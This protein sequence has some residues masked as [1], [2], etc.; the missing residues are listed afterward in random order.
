LTTYDFAIYRG[1]TFNGA[2]F[3]VSVNASPPD[4]T[5]ASI[6]MA[7]RS[8]INF[9]VASTLSTGAGL[10]ITDAAQGKFRIDPQ[11][12]NMAPGAYSYDIQLTVGGVVKTYVRG[13]VTVTGDQ[14]YA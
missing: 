10:T 9:A 1:D 12:F 4:L 2:Q 7:I 8:K 6:L 5:G 14:S 3:T 13:T 11:V